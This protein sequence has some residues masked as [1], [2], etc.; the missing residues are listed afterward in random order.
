MFISIE[1]II[2]PDCQLIRAFQ[3]EDAR[4]SF[5]KLFSVV[6]C[7]DFSLG[8][9]FITTS[10]RGVLRG[11]HLQEPPHA[12]QKLVFCMRGRAY[13]VLVDLRMESPA[14]GK[15]YECELSPTSGMALSIA[16]GVAH[17]FLALDEDTVM[18]YCTTHPH[19]P[20]S[21]KGVRWDSI[22]AAWP[23]IPSSISLRDKALPPLHNY[24]SPFIYVSKEVS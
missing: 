11:M 14:Y 20:D 9:V 13:D 2:L 24:I 18:L 7:G 5:I 21:D 1:E 12:H 15:L 16:P 3:F 6:S 4:G 19:F 22:G 17:G 10:K 23:M 8:E